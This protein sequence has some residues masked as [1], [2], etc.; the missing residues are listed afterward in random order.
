LKAI[1]IGSGIAGIASA[2]RLANKGFE[3]EVFESNAYPGGKLTQ[4]TLGDY[5]FDAGPSLFTLPNL[6]DELFQI[7]GKN[8]RDFFNYDKKKICCNYFWD[9]GTALT[10]Y[11]DE[12]LFADE[13]NKVLGVKKEVISK[14]L[15]KSKAQYKLTES[16]FLKK[17]L[18]KA[19]TYFT[20]DVIK[21][22]AKITSLD[23]NKSM[24]EANTNDL[25]HPKLIQLFNRFATYNGSSPYKAPGVLNMIPHLEHGLGTYFPQ[26]GMHSITKA[27]FQLAENLGVVFHFNKRV[28]QIIVE[29]KRVKG[30]LVENELVEAAIVLSNMDIV[31]TYRKLLANVKA[32]EKTLELERSSS[33]IIFYWGINKSFKQL[34]LHNIF[35]STN[36]EE[37]FNCLF[38]KKSLYHDPSIYI[39]IS[40]KDC[41]SDAPNAKENWFVM[42]NAP[43]DSGQNW[44]KLICQARENILKK[45]NSV[46]NQNIENLIEVEEILHP[47]LIE[48]KT[49][50]FAGA[51]YGSSSN[52]K[53]SA[54]LRHPNF[55]KQIKGLYFAGGSV[56][57]GGG[58]PLCLLSAAIACDLITNDFLQ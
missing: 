7:S 49:S 27:L 39:N 18:H 12:Q 58:I 10:A 14:K 2:I 56:H 35:F 21:A 28:S 9:D 43:S 8:P 45:L 29:K 42:I 41:P 53:F 54:F 16:I 22:I 26:G 6:V 1:V 4:F 24:H 50:S 32:P 25:Q 37:E 19:Y 31:P 40:S 36:Y 5:R 15:L 23:L 13:V 57:P 38:T 20:S 47:T 44:D 17:S 34:D 11:A 46:F 55:A 30:V 51:L 3:V 52:S 48:Q 33:A